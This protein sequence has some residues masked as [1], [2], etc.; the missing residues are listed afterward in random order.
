MV[1]RRSARRGVAD[2]RRQGDAGSLEQ[3]PNSAGGGRAQPDPLT[4]LGQHDVLQPVK[5]AQHI[6]PFRGE[7]R[8]RQRSNSSFCSTRARKEQKTWPRMAA[9]EEW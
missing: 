6:V 5:V 3:G 2:V 4:I 8:V 7:A 9:L 1:E